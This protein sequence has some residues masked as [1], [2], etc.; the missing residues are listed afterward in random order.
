MTP[1]MADP[2]TPERRT[3]GAV[4][5]SGVGGRPRKMCSHRSG[6]FVEL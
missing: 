3:K 4:D 5:I 6:V 1:L 2:T